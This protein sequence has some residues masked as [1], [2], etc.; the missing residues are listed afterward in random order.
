MGVA[1]TSKTTVR[2]RW[3]I[4][5]QVQ[6]VGFRPFVYRLAQR[7][8]L[9]GF[10]RNDSG[11]VIIEVQGD[12]EDIRR[13]DDGLHTQMPP[14]SHIDRMMEQQ[15]ICR[16]DET[17]FRIQPSD[18]SG[19]ARAVVTVDS[20]VCRDCLTEFFDS[21]NRRYRYALINCTN[22]GPRYTIIQRIPYDRPNTTMAE[23]QMCEACQVEYANPDD[24]RFHAQ[25]IACHDCGP[26]VCLETSGGQRVPGDPI[27]QAA[28]LLACGKIVAIKGL[29]GF[30]LAVRADS[31]AAVERLRRLKHR[32]AKP[33]ALMCQSETASRRLVKLSPAGRELL[34]SLR[35]PILLAPR[36]EEA[37]IAAAVAPNNNRL[38]VM[39]AYTP[40]HHLLL[41]ELE[42]VEAALPAL[43]MTSGNQS[44]E[45]LVI[46]HT[47]A[48]VRLG[49]LCD[50]LLLH[51]RPIERCVDD[52]VIL[53]MGPGHAPLPIRR[54]RGFVPA[55][56]LLPIPA[57][58]T[59]LCVGGE[60]KNTVAVVRGAEVILSQ[61]LGDLTH[62]LA[63][64]YFQKAIADLCVLFDAPPRWIAH[65]L[66]PMYVSTAYGARL[67]QNERID[68]IPVQH[69]HAHAAA[70]LAEHGL[71][72]PVLAVLCDGTGLGPDGAGWGGEL[73]LADLAGFRRLASVQPLELPG[74]DAAA[75]DIRRCG[76]AILFQALG[77]AG[78][79]HPAAVRL[80]PD[81][82]ERKMFSLMLQRG[83]QCTASSGVGRLFDGLAALL[84]L[85]NHNQFEA[86][87]ALAVEAAA[88]RAG[89]SDMTSLTK[90]YILRQDNEEIRIDLG[91]FWR[92]LLAAQAD[93]APVCELAWAFHETLA[94]AWDAVVAEQARR[95]GV[96]AAALSGG[97]FC[98]QRFTL[99]LANL[100]RRR[101]LKVL[102][103]QLAPPNDGGL[104]L[105]QAAV[106]AAQRAGIVSAVL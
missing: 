2:K 106:A 58:D 46:D 64:E 13:F 18:G 4:Q 71:T 84:G 93:G 20:G 44:D 5:G 50:A 65:D 38:G 89:E 41:A 102:C 3:I 35:A 23:F 74:G 82:V 17:D 63:L 22:C 48:R 42:K 31:A 56:L 100:L 45:P 91:E 76:L 73:L 92:R 25:P 21:A 39:L 57:P 77:E 62:P 94:L 16:D 47:Q 104:S 40:I 99:R 96:K 78:I 30:H 36:R 26:T 33:F 83:T 19:A 70:V 105:G 101:G 85:A 12:L 37:R 9:T 88:E 8:H 10:I 51:D 1:K 54:S 69:H 49:P 95:T 79:E 90:T 11:G 43:V 6:G 55:P 52:S 80:V 98:N 32:D 86:Q 29:G 27:R 103:H 60:L 87:A 7:G 67:A 15:A 59:G 75:R 81:P 61:H 24:R 14:L 72:G 53:D 34:Q 68:M 66:H 97:V 28:E